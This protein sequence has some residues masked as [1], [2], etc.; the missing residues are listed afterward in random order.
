VIRSIE[1]TMNTPKPR[2]SL[3][4]FK[5]GDKVRFTDDLLNRWP[6]GRV[7]GSINDGRISVEVEVTGRIVPFQVFPHRIERA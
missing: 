4:H 1:A 3:H 2:K 7:A 6:P 5:T